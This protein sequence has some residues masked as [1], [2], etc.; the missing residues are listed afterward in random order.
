LTH[1]IAEIGIV[2]SVKMISTDLWDVSVL[3]PKIAA[4]TRAGQFVHVRVSD[5][6]NPFLRR[7]LSVG[8]VQGDTLRLIFNVRGE[9]TRLLAVKQPGDKLDLI[10][11]LGGKFIIPEDDSILIFL[12]GGIGVVPLLLLDDQLPT[13]R[14]RIFILGVR[15]I[16]TIP[17][18][19]EEASRR[20]IRWASDDGTLGYK[21]NSVALL[22]EI[23][24]RLKGRPAT[25]FACGPGVMLSAM[26]KLT[27]ERGIP[28]F[29]SLE[30]PMGCGVGACQ[31]CA[32]PKAD[33]SGYL[34]VCKDGP[35]FD[36]RSVILEPEVLP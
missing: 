8:P 36:C 15:S 32:V 28:A 24:D 13:E 25:V 34:L 20:N 1:P 6:F 16:N 4:K 9:G 10:G 23:L 18:L 29:A 3:S 11:P 30:V 27:V 31:S 5:G 26:K 14:E 21:G 22:K 7:P 33:G 17:V 12:T 35:V 19:I 2:E